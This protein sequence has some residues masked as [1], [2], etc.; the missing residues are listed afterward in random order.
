MNNRVFFLFVLG[1]AASISLFGCKEESTTPLEP[2]PRNSLP[3]YQP[4]GTITGLIKD[5]CTNAAVSGAMLSV[6]YDGGV[7]S[8]TSDA[9]GAFSFA[10]VPV[11]RFQVVGGGFVLTGTYTLTASLVSFN[12]SQSDTNRRYRDYYYNTVTITFT[13][14]VPGDSL[15]VSGLVGSIVFNISNLNNIVAGQV[16]DANMQPVANA[17]VTLFDQ[18]ITPGAVLAQ[19]TTSQLGSYRFTRVDNGLTLMIKARSSDGSLEGSLASNLTLRCNQTYDSLR[20]QVQAERIVMGPA[21]NVSPFVISIN[22]EHNADVSPSGLQIVYTFS[23]PIKQTAYTRTGLP[24]GHNTMIDDIIFNYDG[25]KKTTGPIPFTV[26]WNSTF[27]QLT[28][29]PQGVVGSARYSVNA[30]TAFASGKI[31]D[32]ANRALVNNANIIGDFEI[33]R[34]TT[35]GASAL[36]VA[37]VLARRLIPGIA[38]QLDYA[39]GTVS[40]EWNYDVNARSYNIYKSVGGGAFELIRQNYLGVQFQDNSGTLY[41][42]SLPNPYAATTM[43]Y[44]VAGVS[45]DLAEGP[46]SNAMT[47]RDGVRPQVLW[48]NL[49]VDSTSA[50][51]LANNSYY[52]TI[53]FREPLNIA[54]AQNNPSTTYVFTNTSSPMT[55]TRADYLG[56]TGP[57]RWEVRIGASPLGALRPSGAAQPTLTVRSSITDLAGNSLDTAGQVNAYRFSM[58]FFDSFEASWTSAGTTPAGWTK[59]NVSGTTNWGQRTNPLSGQAPPAG[60][61]AQEGA[62]VAWFASNVTVGNTTRIETPPIDLRSASTPRVQFYYVNT[63]GTDVLRVRY[64][65][66]GGTTW[67]TAITLTTTPSNSWQVQNLSLSAVAGRSDVKIGFEAVADNGTSDIWI[68]NVLVVQ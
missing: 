5:A 48:A 16:V 43:E 44:K 6:G 11:G 56:S 15:G 7:Q 31:T 2:P 36:P 41:T 33:L 32:Q 3:T 12:S 10:N 68:D 35:N 28:V 63:Q 26:Q 18:S 30:G 47:I 17:I 1:I 55:V 8:A 38:E 29:V 40:M 54:S 39:G 9:A 58:F 4:K 52:M 46:A 37:P 60:A 27:T 23:E 66:D 22:P 61:L 49:S 13:A 19:T 45:R 64:S 50:T 62:S 20:S 24:P 14:L 34:I 21:D 59:T 65:T 67:I 53:S 42:G 51:A 57:S 25:L